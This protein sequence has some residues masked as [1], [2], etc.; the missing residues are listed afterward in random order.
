MI[1]AAAR[2]C[3]DTAP[4]AIEPFDKD[5]GTGVSGLTEEPSPFPRVNRML[6]WVKERDSTADSQRALIVT[7]GYKKYAMLP[8]NVK[9][10]LI[11]RD[12]LSTVEIHIWPD[13]LIVGELAAEPCGAPIYPEFSV[14]WLCDEFSRN[15][16][17]QR[18]NDRYVVDDKTK[19]D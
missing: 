16:M 13:E 2:T 9:W 11:M 6:R 12:I 3:A 14:D 8:Q 10:G 5:W 19:A 18:T 7:E 15:V 17:E 4:L 1:A